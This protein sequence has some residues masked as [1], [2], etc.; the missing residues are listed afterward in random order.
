MRRLLRAS[1]ALI[2]VMA[3]PVR[4]NPDQSVAGFVWL[5]GCWASIGGELGTGEMWTAPAGGTM[6]GVSRTVRDGKTSEYEFM[7]IRE[8]SPGQL[9]FVAHPSGQAQAAFPLVRS[10]PGELVFE[11]PAHDFP[12]RVI[13]RLVEPDRL[14][15]RIEGMLKGEERGV[16]FHMQRAECARR[17]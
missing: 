2:L 14:H 4:S 15:A 10:A 11:D 9:A 5:A 17:D 6:F 12:Q 3:A 7:Q 13:Y 8:I 1:L 16:D